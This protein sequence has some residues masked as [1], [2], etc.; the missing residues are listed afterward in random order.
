MVRAT[1]DLSAYLRLRGVRSEVW[2]LREPRRPGALHVPAGQYPVD[3]DPPCLAIATMS[4][5][6]PWLNHQERTRRRVRTAVFLH[7]RSSWEPVHGV[8]L[9]NRVDT[10]FVPSQTYP[11]SEVAGWPPPGRVVVCQPGFDP[12]LYGGPGWPAGDGGVL[13]FNPVFT[14]GGLTLLQL[15]RRLPEVPFRLVRG[16]ANPYPGL[17]DCR[18]VE[19]LPPQEDVRPLLRSARA[20]LLASRGETFGR[21]LV[22]AQAAGLPVVAS[23]LPVLRATAG[24]AALWCPV[25]DVDA[26]SGAV[27]RLLSDEEMRAA[28]VRA[29]RDNVLRFRPDDD[30]AGLL[31]LVGGRR[32]SGGSRVATSAPPAQ[33]SPAPPSFDPGE[34]VGAAAPSPDAPPLA[35]SPEAAR[36][37]FPESWSQGSRLHV[38]C[39]GKLLPGWLNTDGK[40]GVG[41]DGVVDVSATPL[42]RGRFA[43][44]Y[45]CHVLEHV[46]YHDTPVVLRKLWEALAPGGTLLLSVPD[47]R[48]AVRW[49]DTGRGDP[50]CPLY[51]DLRRGAH[52][53]DRHK[54]VFWHERL[55]KLLGAAGFEDVRPWTPGE[56]PEIAAAGDWASHEEISLNLCGRRPAVRVA[57]PPEIGR[58]SCRERV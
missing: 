17:T 52:E 23:D 55:E 50:N 37:A 8:D 53:F 49:P 22:E 5:I 32:S 18:N 31:E 21:I 6:V 20:L 47:L 26:W 24:D 15:A 19:I 34:H 28:L 16:R 43:A 11:W 46:W 12:A 14:K 9:V 1:E 29:G 51:G 41:P 56:Y 10:W 27:S 58:A 57:A 2:S 36:H 54:Q 35:L 44:V 30:F 25:D 42:P 38:G 48:L 45:A 7:G 40:A 3:D 13:A 33:E 4:A 39:G